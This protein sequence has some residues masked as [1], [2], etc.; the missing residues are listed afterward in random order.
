M[1]IPAEAAFAVTTWVDGRS[2]SRDRDRGIMNRVSV[3]QL[4]AG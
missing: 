4:L 2:A 1:L 3:A